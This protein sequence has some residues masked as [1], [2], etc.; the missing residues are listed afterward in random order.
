[1]SLEDSYNKAVAY[2]ERQ[3]R[4]NADLARLLEE[5]MRLLFR[6]NFSDKAIELKAKIDEADKRHRK[7][8]GR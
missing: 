8:S 2:G 4:H 3:S 6:S 5:A 7:E 1:M